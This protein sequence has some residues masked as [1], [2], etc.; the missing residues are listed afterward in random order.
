MK[1]KTIEYIHKGIMIFGIICMI[2]QIYHF[3]LFDFGE[4][5]TLLIVGIILVGIGYNAE[6]TRIYTMD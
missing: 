3:G 2:S 5:T 6:L 1:E 4:D